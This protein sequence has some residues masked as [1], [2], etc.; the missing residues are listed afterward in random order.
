MS[1]TIVINN[2]DELR[3]TKIDEVMSMLETSKDGLSSKEAKRRL[4]KFGENKIEEKKIPEWKKF[5]K[6]FW[7]PIPW[8]IEIAAILSA[9]LQKWEDFAIITLMLLINVGVDYW[10]ERKAIS[11]IDALKKRLEVRAKVLRDNKWVEVPA[12]KLVPGDIVRIRIGDMVPADIKLINGEY[13]LVDQ[14]TLTGESLPVTK[15]IGDLAYTGTVVKKGSMTG[16]VIATGY[17]TKFGKNAAL[18][19]KAE[20]GK[21]G[22]LQQMVMKITDYLIILTIVLAA[23]ILIVAL[24]RGENILE[25]TRFALVLVVA[26]IPV[27]LPAVLSVTMAIGAMDLA[28]RSAIVKHL[29]AI[30]ELASVDT[31][32]VDKTG[33]LTKNQLVVSK[34]IAYGRYKQKDVIYYALLASRLEDK[35]PLEMAIY[36]SSIK[37]GLKDVYKG[38]QVLS[39]L[40]FDPKIKR[41]EAK[42]KLGKKT[43]EVL[44]GAPQVAITMTNLRGEERKKIEKDVYDLATRGYRTIGV[45]VKPKD[46]WEFVGLIPLYDPPRSDARSTIDHLESL[47]VTVKMV[48]GDNK[49][50][51]KEIAGILGIGENILT[52]AEMTGENREELIILAEILS[53]EIYKR[54]KRKTTEA[55]AD[56]FAREVTQE[57]IKEFEN[58]HLPKGIVRKHETEIAELVEKADG[59]AE[60]YPEHKYLIVNSLQEK[61]H[62]VAMTGDGVNDAPA[63]K[64]ADCGIAV[65]KATDAA[66]MAADIV[67]TA[68]GIKVI[69]DAVV[70]A[71]RIFKRMNTYVI[72]R[73]A[74]TIRVMF[75][76]TLAIIFLNTYPIT[77]IM[78]VLLALLNDIPILTIAYDNTSPSK[79]VEKWE[80]HAII[81]MSTVLGLTGVVS[82][83]LIYYLA[84]YYFQLPQ[85]IVA[86]LIFLKLAI[87]GH[88]TMYLS[89]HSKPFWV[90]PWPSRTLFVTVES[91]QLLAT[92][93]AV[94]GILV[95]PIGWTLALIA[96][97]YAFGW[98]IILDLVKVFT[99]RVMSKHHIAYISD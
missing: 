81:I 44:K 57:I 99:Y 68:L 40:P 51:A 65:S 47:G 19:T 25:F 66:R 35:D 15:H 28:R 23:I 45:A 63:L 43:F 71:R 54:L 42:I 75:F 89:R 26:S 74:E 6:H 33:T 90:K 2:S 76:M 32:C 20:M 72:Y 36:K 41:S 22:H 95:A 93:F 98:F 86:T 69:S 21:V 4:E 9:F 96:W 13:A 97:G 64:K 84:V 77:A 38:V 49:A 17:N 80:T 8:M 12:S 50:I 59:F 91:T 87:A 3:D 61:G 70:E 56:E 88:L 14:S 18:V 37:F 24:F 7:G 10:Q 39:F 92:I 67:L 82:T 1:K 60:V 30:Q 46:K 78:I 83:F 11:A 52:P 79:H 27:A 34:P 55:E 48:T 29:K 31:L 16:V 5:V 73:I 53:K 58:L 94:Y 85:P 62:I